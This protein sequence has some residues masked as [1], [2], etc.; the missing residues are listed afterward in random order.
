[1]NIFLVQALFICFLLPFLSKLWGVPFSQLPNYLKDGAAC[2][3]NVGTLS[4]GKLF[5]SPFLYYYFFL[6]VLARNV[7]TLEMSVV[8]LSIKC[9]YLTTSLFYQYML[10]SY[11][12]K[13]TLHVKLHIKS[14]C[15]NYILFSFMTKLWSVREF[16][17]HW[18]KIVCFV[19]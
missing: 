11:M 13:I 1:M 12:A 18:L 14:T 5:F 16:E 15:E 2:F 17:S 6:K 4:S 10:S 19:T 7:F 8:L 9:I 3:L